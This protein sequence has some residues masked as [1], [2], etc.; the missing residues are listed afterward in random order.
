[1]WM[2]SDYG[3]KVLVVF[4][5]DYIKESNTLAAYESVLKE[6]GVPY[7]SVNVFQLMRKVPD[8]LVKTV[9]VV[10]LPDGILQNV[11]KQ[12]G[13]WI[14]QYLAQGGNIAVIYDVGIKDNNGNYMERATLADIVGLN[15]ITYHTLA[16]KAFTYGQLRFVS[17]EKRD[18]FQIPPG[19]TLDELV[20]SSYGYGSLQYPV[21]RNVPIR[22]I[23]DG[24]IYAYSDTGKSEALPAIL[25]TDYAKGKVLYV[26][27]PLGY[28]KGNSDDM[29][30]RSILRTYLFTVAEVPH[31]ANV[32]Q[33]QGGIVINWHIDS[34][35]EHA[36]LPA[37]Q[38]GG[39]LRPGLQSSFHVTAGGFRD[40]PKDRLGYDAAGAGKD[41]TLMLKNYGVIGSHGGWAH[42]WFIENILN[43]SLNEQDIRKYIALNNDV[44]EKITG[45]KVTEYSAPGGLHPQPVMTHM[46]GDMGIIAYYYTG[47]TGSAPNR[48]F[49]DGKMVSDK[50]IAFP[51]MPL[52]RTASLGEMQDLHYT[53]DKVGEWLGDI[54]AYAARNRTVRLVY[55][56]PYDIGEYPTAIKEF[57]DKAEALQAAGE[58]SVRPMSYYASFFLRFLKT[59]YSF[60]LHDKQLVVSLKNPEGLAG[61]TVAL[62]KAKYQ[63]PNWEGGRVKEDERYYYLVVPDGQET[64]KIITINSR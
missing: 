57:L 61:I 51:V 38:A 58:I 48:T 18:F 42:N 62:P 46:L 21:A 19:K 36:T 17:P 32:D 41:L 26:N 15:Y 33:G 64:E 9:P 53:Q 63:K 60:D 35:V 27:I 24:A 56:H 12:F 44:L 8:E 6:E 20:L 59:T 29:P 45:N 7:A 37:M 25:L 43:G 40:Y 3:V 54:L 4:H 10:L 13:E 28:L 39:L 11:P 5:P 2:P 16:A 30:L 52:G 1:M 49:Y 14:K 55:S 34:S 31:I 47:D 50:V 23:S 22:E